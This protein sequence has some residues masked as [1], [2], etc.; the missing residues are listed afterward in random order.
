MLHDVL[1]WWL[2]GDANHGWLFVVSFYL[3]F[4][5]VSR[6]NSCFVVTVALIE[7]VLLFHFCKFDSLES[8]SSFCVGQRHVD[9]ETS[10]ALVL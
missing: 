9:A 8:F 4:I 1:T 2:I 6:R 5:K 10:F 7:A 3:C